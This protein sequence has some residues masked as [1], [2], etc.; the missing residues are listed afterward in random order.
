VEICVCV[1]RVPMVGGAIV[2]TPDGLDVDTAMAGFTVSPHEECA[3]EEAVQITERL[4]GSVTVL[5]LGPPQAADQLRD[6]LAL[7]AGR[8][9][10]LRTDGAEWGAVATASAL[11]DVVRERRFDLL[12]FGNEA[13]DTGGYQVP[14]RVAHLLG[15]PCVTGIKR[16]EVVAGADGSHDRIVAGRENAGAQETFDLPLPAVVSVKE[17]INLPRYPS[18][19]GRLRAKRATIET[20]ELAPPRPDGLVKQRLRVPAASG[21]HSELLGSGADAVPALVRLLDE[22]GVL[23]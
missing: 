6:M 15:L 7:G 8:A 2:V 21:T 17:G 3:V 14:V 12:L 18:L 23:R 19:P 13:A 10:L 20:V 1:K 9:I 5:T 22:L 11:A 16:L 4:G